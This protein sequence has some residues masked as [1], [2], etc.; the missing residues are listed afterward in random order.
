MTIRW[1]WRV[2]LVLSAAVL[3]VGGSAAAAQAPRS[4]KPGATAEELRFLERHWQTPISPQGE[5]PKKFS[6]LEASL[7]PE[8]CGACHR[9]QYDEWR[10]S[11][12]SK[13]MGPGVLGQTVDMDIGA[14]RQCY[15]CHAPLAEQ[16]EDGPRFAKAL[17]AQGLVCASCHVRQHERFGPPKGDG[18]PAAALPRDQLPH[19][20][21]TRTT[22]FLRAEFCK[23]CHQF[24]AEGFALNGKLLENTY[25]EWRASPYAAQGVQ[26]QDCHMPARQHL[27]RGIHD[28]EMVKRGVTIGLKT[29]RQRYAPG[30]T[31]KASLTITNNG[32]GHFF[33]TYVTPKVFVRAELEDGKGKVVSGSL[34]E[35][36]IGREI[37][38]DLSREVFDTRIPPEKSFVF[39]YSRKLD[40]KG[41]KLRVRVVVDPDH[42]YARFFPAILGDADKGRAMIQGAA[43]KARRSAFTI[44]EQAV[45]LT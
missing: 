12:H 44:F 13:A 4:G 32:V 7:D 6:P 29:D 15:A 20:G 2:G 10:T 3:T 41:L 5:A 16:Q 18:G 42:F 11:L 38:L 21:V 39:T 24:T 1:R 26:C 37:P 45:P 34:K 27:W 8:A 33:P 17:Q 14:A 22:A 25:N 43:E 19:N 9:K 31:L 35:A 23:T 30:D 40:R 36:V 28:P